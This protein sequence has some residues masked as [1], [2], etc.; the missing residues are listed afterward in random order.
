[1]DVA[2]ERAILERLRGW[3]PGATIVAA[4][5]RPEVIRRADRVIH[6]TSGAPPGHPAPGGE[7]V[8]GGPGL[9]AATTPAAGGQDG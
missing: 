6:L 8:P 2:T 3:S 1:V 9:A 7:S 5:S 4:T